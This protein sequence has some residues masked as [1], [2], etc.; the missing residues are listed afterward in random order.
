MT[1]VTIRR[2]TESDIQAIV[3]M[4]ADDSL[5][6]TRETPADLTPYRAAFATLDANPHQLLLVAEREGQVIGTAQLSF[7]PGLS[8]RGMLR[9]DVEA[10]RIHSDARGEGLGST[11]ITHCIEE[12]RSR[13]CGMIQLTSNASRT[14]ARRF[15]ERLGFTASHIGFKMSLAAEHGRS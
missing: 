10:V 6:A 13:G 8:H 12:A 15:Y 4:L 2:A 5:G 11:L 3:D 9:A 14:D 7:M 1:D